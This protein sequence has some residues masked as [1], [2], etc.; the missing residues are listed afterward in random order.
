MEAGGGGGEAQTK[1]AFSF[2]YPFL[3]RKTQTGRQADKLLKSQC[4]V[5]RFTTNKESSHGSISLLNNSVD[6]ISMFLQ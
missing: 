2:F 4:N 3:G 6:I 1:E 5:Y